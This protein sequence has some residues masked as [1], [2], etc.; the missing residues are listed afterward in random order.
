M[1][2]DWQHLLF[3]LKMKLYRYKKL[4]LIV[5]ASPCDSTHDLP[6]ENE[7][8]ASEASAKKANH[9]QMSFGVIVVL[10]LSLKTF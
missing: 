3:T 6:F 8:N 10:L 4:L 2:D 9:R 1:K 7:F 5:V